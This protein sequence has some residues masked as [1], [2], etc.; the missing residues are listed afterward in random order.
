MNRKFISLIPSERSISRL[1]KV[2]D[3]L[4]L[5]YSKNFSGKDVDDFN[6]H[7]T[8]VFSNEEV[9]HVP[10]GEMPLGAPIVVNCAVL[11]RLGE[12][13]TV[14]RTTMCPRIAQLRQQLMA[15]YKITHNFEDFIPHVSLSYV[16]NETHEYPKNMWYFPIEFTRVRVEDV[17][18]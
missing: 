17:T 15:T 7:M 3:R 16:P 5:D 8:L 11:T 18:D 9:N 14:L 13:A 4:G 12:K 1:K 10:N 6:F 2:A